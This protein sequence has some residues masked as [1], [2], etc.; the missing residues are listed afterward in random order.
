MCLQSIGF[1]VAQSRLK[2]PRVTYT[3]CRIDPSVCKSSIS[4]VQQ[5]LLAGWLL[6]IQE[7]W[8]GVQSPLLLP[9]RTGRKKKNLSRKA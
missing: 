1:I 3:H 2:A 9:G 7:S 5:L 8:V 4:K 6:D